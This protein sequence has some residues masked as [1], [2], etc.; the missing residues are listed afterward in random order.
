VP[1]HKRTLCP[2]QEESEAGKLYLHKP[3]IREKISRP[4]SHPHLRHEPYELYWQPIEATKEVRV[5]SE[6][7]SSE[8]F[9]EAHRNLQDSP[10][11]PGCYLPRIIAGLTFASDRVYDMG[12]HRDMTQRK[13][14]ARVDDLNRRNRVYE[15]NYAVDSKAVENILQVDSLVPTAVRDRSL[16]LD[17]YQIAMIFLSRTHFLTQFGF[18]LYLMPSSSRAS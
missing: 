2:E 3:L 7:C 5:H 6:L 11:E 18:C 4:S 14:L 1:F 8:A 9:I 17:A 12:K 10:G 16:L 13:T 15:K